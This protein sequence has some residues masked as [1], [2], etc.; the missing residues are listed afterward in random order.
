MLDFVPLAGAGGQVGDHDVEAQFVGQLLEFAFPQL[1][2]RAVAAAAI[3]GDQ[4]P[5]R[6]GS[7]AKVERASSALAMRS[8]RHGL[9]AAEIGRLSEAVA[10]SL[11]IVYVV[12]GL[13]AVVS[14]FLAL[15]LPTRLSP[16]RPLTRR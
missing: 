3:G 13:V 6:P 1:H 12:A 5:G 4:Q 10:S 7:T 11:H 8:S 2:P 9:G 15:S 14:L 16:T